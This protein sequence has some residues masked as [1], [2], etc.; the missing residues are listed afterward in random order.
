MISKK[1]QGITL[2]TWGLFSTQIHFTKVG[3]KRGT[4]VLVIPTLLAL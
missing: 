4:F 2:C 3:I 1:S